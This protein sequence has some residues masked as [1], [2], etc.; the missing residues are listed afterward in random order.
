MGFFLVLDTGPALDPQQG[1]AGFMGVQPVQE[2]GELEYQVLDMSVYRTTSVRASW[3]E[4]IHFELTRCPG[5]Y[6][7]PGPLIPFCIHFVVWTKHLSLSADL[8]VRF[9]SHLTS[10]LSF[11]SKMF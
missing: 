5:W 6:C 1:P 11:I 3:L 9:D 7:P 2:L 4:K 8:G 10:L